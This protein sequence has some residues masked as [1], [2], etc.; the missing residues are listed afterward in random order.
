MLIV[1]EGIDGAGKTTVGKHLLSMLSNDSRGAAMFSK[2]FG[3][4]EDTYVRNEMSRLRSLIWQSSAE[5]PSVAKFGARYYVFLVAAW[6]SALDGCLL[7]DL[8]QSSDLALFDGWF[9]RTIVKARIREQLPDEWLWSLFDSIVQP[10]VVVMID[11][12]PAVA[13]DRRGSFKPSEVGRWDGYSG[14]PFDS[15]CRYQES[16]RSELLR[17]GSQL[18]WVIVVPSSFSSA[19]QVAA[20]VNDQISAR[21]PRN[22]WPGHAMR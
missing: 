1:L 15:Y 5:E 16:V 6:F 22:G 21:L 7:R 10:D 2:S 11:T 19:L 8:K 9:Y 13:F 3:D 12:P 18:G 17:V 20:Q 4:F 14:E